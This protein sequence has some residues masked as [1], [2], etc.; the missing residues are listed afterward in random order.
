MQQIHVKIGKR[1]LAY[2]LFKTIDATIGLRVS[3]EEEL[4]GL[5]S[6]EHGG[7]A[8]P[9]FT[10][11]NHGTMGFAGGPGPKNHETEPA[12]ASGKLVNKVEMT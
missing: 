6:V 9:D 1:D 8:Y 7:N 10:T 3:R 5:D 2:L 11:I 4:E 12:F